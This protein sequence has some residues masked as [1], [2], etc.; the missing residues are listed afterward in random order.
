MKISS[1]MALA[2][3]GVATALTSCGPKTSNPVQTNL[4]KETGSTQNVEPRKNTEVV[5]SGSMVFEK[6][7]AVELKSDFS[8]IEEVKEKLNSFNIKARLKK[9]LENDATLACYKFV[10]GDEIVETVV[11]AGSTSKTL[12]VNFNENEVE[13]KVNCR[14]RYQEKEIGNADFKLMKSLLIDS[15]VKLQEISLLKSDHGYEL[16]RLIMTREGILYTGDE[17]FT[18]SVEQLSA[19]D[20]II[21][22]F[23]KEEIVGQKKNATG[24]SGGNIL[25][26]SLKSTG[27]LTV[28]MLGQNGDD[29]TLVP[30]KNESRGKNGASAVAE[31]YTKVCES[32]LLAA[33]PVC[34]PNFMSGTIRPMRCSSGPIHCSYE[35]S[36]SGRPAGNGDQG[37][38]GH[39]G[40]AGN[41]GGNSGQFSLVST[42]EANFSIDFEIKPGLGGKGGA[43]GEGGEGGLG[44]AGAGK[45]PAGAQGPVGPRG[46]NGKDGENGTAIKSCT[47]NLLT[48]T[49]KCS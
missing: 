7:R 29:Q 44:G 21:Q 35:E 42:E 24:K 31:S 23:T 43:G 28:R 11:A 19:Q 15:P 36:S 47:T 13:A 14:L 30:R 27:K 3:M 22:T 39:E 17:S 38:R 16:D 41:K 4:S 37:P 10:G 40:M 1:V 18:M 5:V 9:A 2:C 20:S 45:H 34:P 25:L 26:N 8:N 12:E 32:S 49:T 6:T 46:Q 33:G 48:V